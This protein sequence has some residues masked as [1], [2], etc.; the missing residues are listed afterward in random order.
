M[1]V[2]SMDAGDLTHHDLVSVTESPLDPS[3]LLDAVRRPDAGA[4][5]LFLGSVRDHSDR[6]EGVTHL[7]YEAYR[8]VVE[9]KILEIITE[10]RAQW[11]FGSIAAAHRVGTV[12]VGEDSVGVAV[13][14][15]H[16][17]EAFAA[18]RHV[19][20]ELKSRAPIWKKEYWPG[21]AE[22]V[23]EGSG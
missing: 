10:T 2:D 9:A 4:I 11:A 5:V 22:W 12:Q 7:E 19:I 17:P 23:Q 15:P 13:S 18:A 6:R 8:E 21:G 3:A 16:R 1:E 14:A 20:D